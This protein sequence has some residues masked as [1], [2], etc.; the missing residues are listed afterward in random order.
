MRNGYADN[1]KLAEYVEATPRLAR[2][3]IETLTIEASDLKDTFDEFNAADSA[4]GLS[5]E[6]TIFDEGGCRLAGAGADEL[7]S[8]DRSVDTSADITSLVPPTESPLGVAVVELGGVN[9]TGREIWGAKAFLDP[10]TGAGKEVE[11]W[12]CALYQFEGVDIN[13]NEEAWNLRLI[14]SDRVEA[15]ATSAGD[16]CFSFAKRATVPV[17][18]NPPDVSDPRIGAGLSIKGATVV[19]VVYALKANGDIANNVSWRCN[20]GASSVTSGEHTIFRYDLTALDTPAEGST[21]RYTATSVVGVPDMEFTANT[22]YSDATIEWVTTS[23]KLDLGQAPASGTDLEL[24]LQT[25]TP[26]DTSVTAQ[27]Y[28]DADA[29]WYTFVDNDII[30]EDRSSEDGSD[31]SAMT[32]QQ[33]YQVK[34]T[35]STSTDTSHTPRLYRIGVQEVTSEVVDGLLDVTAASWAIDPVTSQSEIPTMSLTLHRD[36][37][38]DYRSWSDELFSTNQLNELLFRVWVGHPDLAKRYWLHIDDFIVG[39]YT[40]TEAGIN[41]ELLSPL[42]YALVEIPPKTGSSRA[43]VPY[44]NATLKSVYDDIVTTQAAIQ[45]RYIGAGIK[46]ETTSNNVTKTL[47]VEEQAV[48]VLRQLNYINGSATISSQ[49]VLKVVSL[50][51]GESPAPHANFPYDELT[52]LSTDTGFDRRITKFDVPYGWDGN[53]YT[54]EQVAKPPQDVLDRLGP[55]AMSQANQLDDGV[56]RWLRTSGHADRIGS[57]MIENFLNGLSQIHFRSHTAKPWLEPGDAV[58][59]ESDV[60]V[61]IDPRNNRALRGRGWSRGIVTQCHDLM[62]HEFTVWVQSWYDVIASNTTFAWDAGMTP[63]GKV[64][65]Q[66]YDPVAEQTQ[67]LWRAEFGTQAITITAGAGLSGGGDLTANRTIAMSRYGFESLSDPDGGG[68]R[69]PFFDDSQDGFQW[70][71]VGS[72]LSITDTTITATGTGFNTAGT[73]LVESPAGTVNIE[74]TTP[75]NFITSATGGL[76]TELNAADRVAI[77]D[78]T[79]NVVHY[80]GLSNLEGYWTINAGSQIT[81][82]LPLANGGTG[83]ALVDPNADRILFWDDSAGAMAFLQIAGGLEIPVAAPTTIQV[84]TGAGL[85]LTGGEVATDL[86]GLGTTAGPMVSTDR[87]IINDDGVDQQIAPINVPLSIFSNDA[88]FTSNAFN[89]AGDGLVSPSDNTVAVDYAGPDNYILDTRS[90]GSLDT[91]GTGDRIPFS[92]NTDNTVYY[93]TPQDIVGVTDITEGQITDGTILARL[94]ADETVSGTYSFSAAPRLNAGLDLQNESSEPSATAGYQVLYS[95]NNGSTFELRSHDGTNRRNIPLITGSAA[96]NQLL[97]STGTDHEADWS[98]TG[99]V[100]DGVD[101]LTA[102]KF[103][104]NGSLLSGVVATDLTI[105]DVAQNA[106][107]GSMPDNSYQVALADTL[108]AGDVTMF[109][110]GNQLYYVTSTD[111]LTGVNAT[112]SGDLDVDGTTNLDA[113]DIDGAVDM[114][115]TLTVAGNVDFNGN[116]DVDGTANLDAVDID[117]NVDMAGTL[118]VASTLTIDKEDATPTLNVI[119]SDSSIAASNLVTLLQARGDLGSGAITGATIAVRADEDWVQGSNSGTRIAFTTS[120]NGTWNSDLERMRID[121]NGNIGIGSQNPG[122]LLELKESSNA[123]G[124]AVIR[125]RGHGNNSDN[126]V[127]GA[128]EWYNADSSGDQPGVVCRIEGVS[129]NANG[130]MGELIFKTHDGSEGGEGSD[131]VERVRIDNSGNVGIGTASPSYALHVVGDVVATV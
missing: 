108:A 38:K 73:G 97:V 70:L 104:G 123:A 39:N 60:Y 52:V 14:A 119:R 76:L 102:T 4:G 103:S 72:G 124:D 116:L 64:L 24:T 36:G 99:L 71:T 93:A 17:V 12:Y 129:G 66:P 26:S 125:L 117:G 47:A 49:G 55:I 126:T 16:V 82:I 15:T 50:F 62:G 65:Y 128:L 8:S 35:L 63:G 121:H 79:D 57:R 61:G 69:L 51:D 110:G 6:F 111:T 53:K 122:A 86:A 37:E 105:T 54:N 43:P 127:L 81:G 56:A 91:S 95:Y 131:P 9:T 59:I 94:A 118:T 78:Q 101:T 28:N 83:A 88:N 27:L 98:G 7:L 25:A 32:R 85:Q 58:A 107:S 21:L 87:L 41:V 40:P 11:Y 20:S 22:S 44:E 89:S 84:D 92:D 19:M 75:A 68:D 80:T 48:D 115:S 113:V 96:N 18:G 106:P 112:L 34:A 46:D 10:N 45:A 33:S 90:A 23:N 1:E 130:H 5:A 77:A 100:W 3:I 109:G 13:G 114:A 42:Q 120:T 74:Y 67:A 30:G 29:T 2:P 31:L